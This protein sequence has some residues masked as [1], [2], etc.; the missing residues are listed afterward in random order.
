MRLKMM[1]VKAQMNV[2]LPKNIEDVFKFRY[3]QLFRKSNDAFR[4]L[5]ANFNDINRRQRFLIGR[6]LIV[7]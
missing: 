7:R 6:F 1:V 3:I 2:L 4:S 5:K